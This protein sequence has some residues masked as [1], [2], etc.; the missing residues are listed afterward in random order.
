MKGYI[1]LAF[2]GGGENGLEVAA[3]VLLIPNEF[4]RQGSSVVGNGDPSLRGQ[5]NR[6]DDEERCWCLH[7]L[8][9]DKTTFQVFN[10]PI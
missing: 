5:Q 6:N 3:A 2:S 9:L 7:E 1:P 8:S 4:T 10:D